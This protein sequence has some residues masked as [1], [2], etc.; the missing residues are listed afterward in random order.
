MFVQVSEWYSCRWDCPARYACY[1]DL[2][3]QN[4][5]LLPEPHYYDKAMYED[6]QD[7][8]FKVSL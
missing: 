6:E 4:G 2:L 1:V 7:T 8:W 3:G 5:T